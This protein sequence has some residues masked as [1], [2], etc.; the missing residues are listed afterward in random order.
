MTREWSIY[1][2]NLALAT[3]K[4]DLEKHFT[5][6]NG[7]I[8]PS[9]AYFLNGLINGLKKGMVRYLD[10]DHRYCAH[11]Q[12]DETELNGESIR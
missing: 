2:T 4:N 7:A 1:V 10:K 3:T 9:D 12:K 8:V 5:L 6:D 11:W